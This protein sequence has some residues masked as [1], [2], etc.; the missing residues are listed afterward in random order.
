MSNE[1]NKNNS[2]NPP[3]R[4]QVYKESRSLADCLPFEPL[5][6]RVLP[7]S[8][9]RDLALISPFPNPSRDVDEAWIECLEMNVAGIL[10]IEDRP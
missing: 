5:M 1:N 3:N 2:L 8:K 10:L 6:P 9:Q 4:D 7:E